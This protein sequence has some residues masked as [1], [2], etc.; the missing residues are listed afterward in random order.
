[1]E[2]SLNLDL[3]TITKLTEE[4]VDEVFF[5]E[6]KIFG[7]AD[8]EKIA[9]TISN[10]KLN[11]FILIFDGKVIGFYEC[12]VIPP[13]AE[14]YDIAIDE[15]FRGIGLGN[16]LL[17]DFETYA[18]NE[19]CNT[20]LLEVNKINKPAIALYEKSGFI[21]YGVRKNYYSNNDAILMRKFI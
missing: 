20:L 13:E 10:D 11:Y 3:C 4:Y 19:G 15:K 2:L 8:R 5:L 21:A 12:F 17:S 6:Q 14:L 9:S 18:K 7:N 1:M 16:K